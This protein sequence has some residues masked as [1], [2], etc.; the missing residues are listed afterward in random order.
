MNEEDI[1]A[2]LFNPFT[3]GIFD[4]NWL[5]DRETGIWRAPVATEHDRDRLREIYLVG[6][7][8][9]APFDQVYPMLWRL[10]TQP[11][12]P[13]SLIVAVLDTGCL[14]A[15]PLLA[16]CIDETI[17]FTSEGVEDRIGHGTGCTLIA[18]NMSVH[19]R[20]HLLIG[21]VFAE[22]RRN[23]AH[24]LIRGIEWA[25]NYA[26][27]SSVHVYIILR[28]GL[29]NR[30]WAGLRSCDGTCDVC[31]VALRAVENPLVWLD[32]APGN[33]PRQTACP[34][35]AALRLRRK[36]KEA[37]P[38]FGADKF[39]SVAPS[40]YGDAGVGT[41]LS[42]GEGLYS[43]VSDTVT[44]YPPALYY[45]TLDHPALA[46]GCEAAR[47]YWGEPFIAERGSWCIAHLGNKW[48]R[49]PHWPGTAPS[50]CSFGYGHDAHGL[51]FGSP[52]LP[53]FVIR[54][55]TVDAIHA[56]LPEAMKNY[57]AQHQELPQAIR[58][59]ATALADNLGNSVGAQLGR[60]LDAAHTHLI[61]G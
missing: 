23:V 27:K 39:V 33:R 8:D 47:R 42:E 31:R 5:R 9:P 56:Q 16:D 17:D 58:Q 10:H 18:R 41:H 45:K 14:A 20:P 61:N 2:E 26:R 36:P 55:T 13:Q 48:V 24:N 54:G 46:A 51:F 15:H 43:Y 28:L 49:V 30:R 53:G 57:L 6:A 29:Y 3:T 21:K 60:I 7:N 22:D 12:S 59:Q 52:A 19:E 4:I 38:S 1:E 35:V 37:G 11:K 40:G 44:L 50:V 34:A 32:A 25:A